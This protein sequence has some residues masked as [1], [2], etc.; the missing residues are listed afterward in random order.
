[1][2]NHQSLQEAILKMS[3]VLD[4]KDTLSQKISDMDGDKV[5]EY[6]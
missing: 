5:E 2:S 1:M 4:R 6:I 3:S